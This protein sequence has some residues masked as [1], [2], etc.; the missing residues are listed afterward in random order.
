ME[1]RE[2]EQPSGLGA[3]IRRRV[4]LGVAGGL[5]LA[6][7]AFGAALGDDGQAPKPTAA[8]LLTVPE[9][10]GERVVAGFPGSTVPAPVRKMIRM[11]RLAGV[12][13]FASNFPTRDAGRAL[14]ADLQSIPR[15]SGLRSPLLIMTDQEGGL[16]KRLSGA[17]NASAQEM[18]ARGAAYS[19][20]QGRLTARN[21]RN[22]G[23]NVDL[24]PVLDVARPG[25]VIADTDRGFGP[26]AATVIRTAI[27][28]AQALSDGGV[29]TTA[30]HFPGLGSAR[31]NTDFAVQHI[32]LSRARLRAVD[33]APYPPF[34]G[35]R[36]AVVMVNSAIYPAFSAKPASFTRA[37][38]T[39]ELRVRLHFRGVSVT[40]A[41]GG[42]A[43]GAFGGPGQAGVSAAAA[44][45]DLL[46]FSDYQSGARAYRALVTKLRSHAL[47]RAAF[48]RSVQRVL[49]LRHSFG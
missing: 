21:L 15:P 39:R 34:I 27:P 17:P 40:D 41:L 37:I 38:A 26:D 30:K 11:G 14:I 18:G 48:E 19:R 49:E 9:L 33:E 35:I 46:L 29:A 3:T 23:V 45:T 43:I 1:T 10:A 7:F 28:F 32:G 31:Q 42:A 20:E 25:G 5:A 13:L 12:V 8:S 24:A 4:A 44:G 36:R 6:A 2:Q 47:D 22:V 16:V